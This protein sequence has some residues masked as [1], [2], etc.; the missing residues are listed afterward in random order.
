M[1]KPEK[2]VGRARVALPLAVVVPAAAVAA[3][4]VVAVKTIRL[5]LTEGMEMRLKIAC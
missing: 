1:G 2:K 4:V 5:G 3:V